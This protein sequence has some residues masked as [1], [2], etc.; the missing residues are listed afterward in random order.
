MNNK[1]LVLAHMYTYDWYYGNNQRILCKYLAFYAQNVAF[2]GIFTVPMFVKICLI[3]I[4]FLLHMHLLI[5]S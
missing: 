2:T 5:L 3:T 4:L 1:K